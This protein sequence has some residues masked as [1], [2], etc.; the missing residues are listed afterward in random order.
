MDKLSPAELVAKVEAA[1]QQVPIG[2]KWQHY[3]GGKYVVT[4]LVVIELTNEV[5]VVYLSLEHP[6]VKFLRPLVVW[7]EGVEWQGEKMFRFR[8]LSNG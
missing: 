1:K 8:F 6:S 7:Q 3:K 5:A 4:D 2:S